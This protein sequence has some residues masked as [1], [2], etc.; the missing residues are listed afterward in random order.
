MSNA[1]TLIINVLY[2]HSQCLVAT[3]TIAV[4]GPM[5][6]V[7]PTWSEYPQTQFTLSLR[8]RVFPVNHLNW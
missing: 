5:C 3:A 8:R 2:R 1:A 4:T 7:Q 6:Y